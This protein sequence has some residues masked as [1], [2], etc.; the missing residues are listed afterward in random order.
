MLISSCW[1]CCF[2]LFKTSASTFHSHVGSIFTIWKIPVVGDHR[3]IRLAGLLQF[4][5]PCASCT[6]ITKAGGWGGGGWLWGIIVNKAEECEAF[7]AL[8]V[9]LFANMPAPYPWLIVP[10]FLEWPYKNIQEQPFAAGCGVGCTRWWM[11]SNFSWGSCFSHTQTHT[12]TRTNSGTRVPTLVL[13]SQF[14]CS[15][16]ISTYRRISLDYTVLQ[17][18]LGVRKAVLSSPVYSLWNDL[19]RRMV[20]VRYVHSTWICASI[21]KGAPYVLWANILQESE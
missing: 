17:R 16:K 18:C 15:Y 9:C 8:K 6:I 7:C 5:S 12:H 11:S 13:F 3:A 4:G 10:R 20:F 1:F 2:L 14:R 19:N 21:Q